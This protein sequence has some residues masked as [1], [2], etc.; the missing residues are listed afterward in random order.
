MAR[1]LSFA[2]GGAEYTVEPVKVDRKKL[3]GWS[4]VHAYDDSGNEC[5]LVSTDASGTVI[6]PRDGVSL[7]LLSQDG[8]WVARNQLKTVTLDGQ[9]ADK[10]TS[11]YNR[12]NVLAD[13]ATD[14]DV[15]DCSITSFYHLA[16]ADPGLVDAVGDDIYRFEY[17]Y[18]DSYEP[19]PAF[20]MTSEIDGKKEL[21]M[22]IGSPNNFTFIGLD[23]AVSADE[24]DEEEDEEDSDEIDFGMF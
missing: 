11:S 4:E 18:L 15:L 2:I 17:C 7:G 9:D 14:E 13:K 10:V 22:L 1:A 12:V 23:G 6:I 21:F 8:H 24:P 5:V 3:Y 16:S 19:S 20:L